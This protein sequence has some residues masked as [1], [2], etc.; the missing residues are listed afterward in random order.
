MSVR[1]AGP[2]LVNLK[3]GEMLVAATPCIVSTL[4]GSCVAVTF[5]SPRDGVGA[6]CHALLPT[7][8]GKDVHGRQE[9]F[10]YV[11]SS[12]WA[13]LDVFRRRGILP[14]E[15]E[16]KLFGGADMF[17]VGHDGDVADG[18]NTVGR[19]NVAMAEEVLAAEGVRVSASDVGGLQGRKILFSTRTGEVFLRRVSRMV[20]GMRALPESADRGGR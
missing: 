3:S 17:Y 2:Q 1:E 12:L 8:R 14:C 11:D 16:A 18:R 9:Q 5:F 7:C 6:I 15:V 20:Q 4:L 10:R 19:Q 13:M